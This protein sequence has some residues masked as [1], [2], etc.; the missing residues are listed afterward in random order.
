[1]SEGVR[2]F[3]IAEKEELFDNNRRL[4]GAKRPRII[5]YGIYN[6]ARAQAHRPE[7]DWFDKNLKA[8]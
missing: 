8:R 6:K 3:L 2:L 1:M 5:H 7:Q 4:R